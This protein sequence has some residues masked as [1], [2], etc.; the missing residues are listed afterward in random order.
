[1]GIAIYLKTTLAKQKESVTYANKALKNFCLLPRS[2]PHDILN[3]LI[4]PVDNR[5]EEEV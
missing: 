3:L 2:L 1:M 5:V 4:E